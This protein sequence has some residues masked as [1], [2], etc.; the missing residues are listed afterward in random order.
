MIASWPR[1]IKSGAVSNHISAFWDVLPTF[2][3]IAG[4][5]S[6]EDADGISFLPV[7]TGKKQ[8][9]HEYLY[10]EFPES[11]GQQAVIIANFK[12]LRKNMHKGNAE[13]ELFDLQKDPRET[14]NIAASHPEI[15]QQVQEIVK[16]EHLK[17]PNK[18]WN[19]KLLD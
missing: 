5:K 13:F 8:K 3:D 18:L 16:K 10:W 2:C 4:V 19:F 14:T 15:I 11:G 6:P 17:S 1:K 9:K 12:A 7:L